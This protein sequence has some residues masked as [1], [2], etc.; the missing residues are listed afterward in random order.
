[1]TASRTNAAASTDQQLLERA[2][3]GDLR[4]WELI[5]R[6]HQ[7][8]VFRVGFL[9]T[10]DA[11]RSAEATRAAFIRAFR[12]IQGM[13]PDALLRPW[14]LRIGV[15]VARTYRRE[16]DRHDRHAR[17]GERLPVPRHPATPRGGG[18][19]T[20]PLAPQVREELVA[21]FETLGRDDRLVIASR[22]LLGLTRDEAAVLVDL[23]ADQLDD[24]LRRAIDEVRRRV[25]D[26]RIAAVASDR[27]G[28]WVMVAVMSPLT[29][30][31][32]VAGAV[33]DGLQREAIAY[34]ELFGSPR[35]VSTA[36]ATDPGSVSEVRRSRLRDTQRGRRIGMRSAT[37]LAAIGALLIVVVLA[38]SIGW[39]AGPGSL[40]PGDVGL[41]GG[42]HPA[43]AA[44]DEGTGVRP[45]AG[46]AQA[47]VSILP[48]GTVSARGDRVPV[49]VDW[50]ESVPMGRNLTTELQRRVANGTW[51][52]IASNGDGQPVVVSVVPG[53]RYAFRVRSV[54]S[55]GRTDV[56]HSWRT[57]LV[58]RDSAS[59]RLKASG[60]RSS[61]LKEAIG[62]S[63]L[64]ASVGATIGTTFHGRGVGVVAAIDSTPTIL[65]VR[66][67]G[68]P[69]RNEP[70]AATQAGARRVV[71]SE[72]LERGHHTLE[73][74]AAQ[75]TV[76][77]DAILILR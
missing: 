36:P 49:Q 8:P 53:R 28:T 52:T 2:R 34:P 3:D 30:T 56:V 39:P 55:A 23:S 27:L 66:I 65:R 25:P 64:A 50:A 46:L 6:R 63:T 7:Q 12:S 71:F 77:L 18:P 29:W 42:G 72:R 47:G 61:R 40:R 76:A 35:A 54:G 20:Q 73:V 67:D 33:I 60:A 24:R 11:E 57:R 22:Y 70:L 17:Q 43:G 37:G 38:A 15:S 59:A 5:V 45:V 1:M 41:P 4:A 75:G 68:G 14:L 13:A 69:W 62:R 48:G 32:D 10:G 9:V 16:I 74:G 26:P 51:S 44:D 21:A 19:A 31:P 58:V